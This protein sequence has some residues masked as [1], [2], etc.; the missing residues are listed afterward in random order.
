MHMAVV[1]KNSKKQSPFQSII[2]NQNQKSIKFPSNHIVSHDNPCIQ[3]P[4]IVF[5]PELESK[6]LASLFPQASWLISI[7]VHL[8]L[9]ETQVV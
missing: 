5:F 2:T 9:Q 4:S 7:T 1:T 3:N 6:K 8:V